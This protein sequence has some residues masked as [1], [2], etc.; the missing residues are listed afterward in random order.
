MKEKIKHI[1]KSNVCLV[2]LWRGRPGGCGGG[3]G[4][5]IG[6]VAVFV[7]TLLRGCVFDYSCISWLFSWL[8]FICS[9][10]CGFLGVFVVNLVFRGSVCDCIVF[11]GCVDEYS[12]VF[13]PCLW[14]SLCFPCI[15]AS[16]L[17]LFLVV[18]D[19]SPILDRICYNSWV[20]YFFCLHLWLILSFF[21]H[22]QKY[23]TQ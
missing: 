6:E 2:V 10:S 11:L 3:G 17:E 13:C 5:C 20:F 9:Y 16:I 8:H 19:C 22:T 21:S 14:F 23:Y 7:I 4:G 15:C 12:C 1:E 18:C